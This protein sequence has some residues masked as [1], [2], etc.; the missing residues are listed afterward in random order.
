[1]FYLSHRTKI[2][3]KLSQPFYRE[4][5]DYFGEDIVRKGTFME[6]TG[7]IR[8]Y[9]IDEGKSFRVNYDHYNTSNSWVKYF[10][11]NILDDKGKFVSCHRAPTLKDAMDLC[12]KS[13]I[14][15]AYYSQ[16]EEN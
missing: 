4:L 13:I 10:W 6:W 8:D 9:W 2:Q 3:N 5:I 11:V 14:S 15:R 16:T 7:N 12:A 1:M